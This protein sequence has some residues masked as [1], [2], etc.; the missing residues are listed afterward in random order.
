MHLPSRPAPGPADPAAG[1]LRWLRPAAV[2]ALLGLAGTWLHREYAQL[3]LR[4]ILAEFHAIPDGQL[5]LALGLT[6]L[7]YWILGFYDVLALR[8]AGKS[9]RYPRALY[10]SF[11]AYALGNNLSLAAFT[12]AAVR[13]RLYTAS[14][15][16]AVEVA[17]VAAFCS[18]S[19]ALGLA[20]LCAFA[21]LLEPLQ[22]AGALHL[23]AIG[24]TA[25]GLAL[26][27]VVAAYAVWATTGRARLEIRGW[28]LKPPGAATGLAQIVLA[29]ADL[30]VAAAVLWVLLP[31]EAGLDL[32]PFAGLYAIAV[33]A[34]LLSQ[35]PG[36]V[37]VF[38]AIVALN[39]PGVP[40]PKLFGALLAYRA[41]YYLVPLVVAAALFLVNELRSRGALIARAHR[42]TTA[43]IAPVVPQVVATLIFFAGTVLLVSGATPAAQDRLAALARFLPLP[44][45]E[46][47]HLAGSVIGLALLVLAHALLRRVN[48]A[49]HIAFWLLTAGIVAS[50]AKG[51]D[52]EEA[53]LLALVLGILV[54]G[55]EA[56][57]RPTS[58]LED[59]Y[60]PAWI[61]SIAGVIAASAFIALLAYRHVVFTSDLWWTFAAGANAP[62]SLR[63]LV[64]VAM[65]ATAWLLL[66]LLRPARPAPGVASPEELDRARPLIATAR[67]TLANVAL[68]GDKRLL[69]SDDG[70]GFLMYQVTGPTW[71]ALGDPVGPRAQAEELV[72]RLRELSDRH[73]ARVAFY[74]VSAD[75]LPL[76]VDLGLALLK[77]GEEGRVALAG[78]TLEGSRNA[79]LRQAHRRS[80]RDG[81]SFRVAP[82]AQVPEL[83]PLLGR[84]SDGWLEDKAT[85]EKHFSLGAFSGSYLRHF[86]VALVEIG[87]A[88]VAFANLWSAGKHEE[89][90]VDLMRF[91]RDAPRGAMDFLFTELMLWG[92][93]Q[94]YA[95]FNLGMAPLAGLD[96][97]PLAPAWHRVGN[98]VFQHGEH[99]YNFD[100][101][102]RYKEKFRPTWEPKYLAARGGLT[103]PRTLL[104]IS[105]LVSGGL[106]EL[107]AK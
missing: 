66:G 72:W 56:F 27:G 81:A 79:D 60:S 64:L 52:Y 73:G 65:I 16:T 6:V 71:V 15:L 86:D 22:A 85:A 20:T 105:T 29:T 97:H 51:V 68:T 36:G 14:G 5:G 32:L 74:Q 40:S 38:E 4:D 89:L 35:V 99:F 101:L 92:R 10:T 49:Y 34:G 78:F 21:L 28:A 8:Y 45:L 69:F 13:L 31:A 76:Y 58:I 43:L 1:S 41:I 98:F 107:F 94:G 96:H 47:S 61:A 37:G 62:R 77:I 91:D 88:P 90:S 104:D 95:W 25:A 7:S 59:R 93:S 48:A 84:I 44:M 19:V 63:A 39:L 70:T 82:A 87:G 67:N 46:L 2:L 103:L 11:I 53:L 24:S 33:A 18:L 3:H 80:Q 75:L 9:I 55:R 42:V 102:R 12:G 57:Y 106:R 100:G 30:L 54:L 17:T 26:L 83:L 50:L 23:H